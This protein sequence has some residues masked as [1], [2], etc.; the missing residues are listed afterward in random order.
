ML[1]RAKVQM[2]DPV[3]EEDG[4]SGRGIPNPLAGFDFVAAFRRQFWVLVG[5]TSVGVLVGLVY[6]AQAIPTYTSSVSILIDARK[7][8]MTAA[9]PL[10]GSL[11]FEAGAIDSQLQILMSDKL[12]GAVATRLGLQNNQAFIDPPG[13]FLSELKS[14]VTGAL[15]SGINWVRG[16]APSPEVMDLPEPFRLLIASRRLQSNLQVGRI[17]RTYVFSVSYTDRDPALAQSIAGQYS[18]AY[19]EDQL[20]SK[21]DATR[22]ATNW[23]EERIR[24][25]RAQSLS[26]DEAVQKYKADNN[27]VA[28]SGRLL[29][30]QTLTDATTRLTVAQN[31]LDEASARYQ[32]LKQIVDNQ[33]VNASLTE[34]FENPNIA[35]L[36]ARYLQS[37]KLESEISAQYGT[38]HQAAQKAR[39]DMAEYTRLIFAELGNL[40]PGYE[41]DV[42]IARSQ[43][44][45]V[46]NTIDQLRQTSAVNDTAMVKLRSLEQESETLK[47]LYSTFLQKAQE[48]QQQQSFPVTDARVISDA[49]IPT[50][51]SSP[52]KPLTL[53]IFL[54]LGGAIGLGIGLIREWRDRGLRTA[55]QIRDEL[56]LEFIANIPVIDLPVGPSSAPRPRQ[57]GELRSADGAPMRRQTVS[58]DRM[59]QRVV[60]DPFSQ[61]AESI[62]ALRFKMST[63]FPKRKGI[64]IGMVS[65]FP[66][67]G[68]TTIAKNLASSIALQGTSTMLIDGDLRNPSLTASLLSGPKTGLVDVLSGRAN[69]A[70][71]TA[72]E[73]ETGLSF[74]A[75]GTRTRAI[76]DIF[77][78]AKAQELID[79]LRRQHDVIIIDF[80]PVGAL[81]DAMAAASMVDGYFFVAHWG[82]TPRHVIR[83]FTE[84]HPEVTDK[85]LGVVLNKVDL[86][87]LGRYGSYQGNPEYAKYAQKYFAT[88]I[89]AN[90]A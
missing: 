63:E 72:H 4:P 28:A 41:S 71:V 67:E 70:D 86:K 39:R 6:L 14:D 10:E 79:H 73:P 45:S 19:L 44:T 25:L 83:E 55:T 11:T 85:V 87:K 84:N 47:V 20:D 77:G 37:A 16:T 30:D 31:A 46:E 60:D 61:F 88:S 52:K 5:A 89:P 27:L 23:M 57:P 48:M 2:S 3:F 40:L 7:V 15:R 65:M 51:P 49:S 18:N 66:D 42:T 24:D 9:T 74:L 62:R 76:A 22:R 78:S 81:T 1:N 36:R 69:L 29:D 13:S 35:Q 8:G 59:L 90:R 38:D 43:V 33:D 32:R 21:F 34:S 80:P 12:A 17:G 50:A 82:K 64:V 58:S 26:A 75:A 56:G 68:K 53:A 54:I